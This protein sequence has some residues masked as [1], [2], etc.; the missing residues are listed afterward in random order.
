MYLLYFTLAVLYD[1]ITSRGGE[2][3]NKKKKKKGKSGYAAIAIWP[4]FRSCNV[5]SSKEKLVKCVRL[6]RKRKKTD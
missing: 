6:R 2:Q 4:L 3:L 1:Q 5:F